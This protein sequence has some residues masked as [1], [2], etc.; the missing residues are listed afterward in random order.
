LADLGCP[1]PNADRNAVIDWM[2]G[3]AVQLEYGDNG[4]SY[5]S[6]SS[7]MYFSIEIG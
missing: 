3:C 4:T 1:F 6:V 5:S 2:L 7:F